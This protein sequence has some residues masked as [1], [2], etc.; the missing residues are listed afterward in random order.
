MQVAVGDHGITGVGADVP[1][2]HLEL[3]ERRCVPAQR[4]SAAP[5]LVGITTLPPAGGHAQNG[6]GLAGVN[7]RLAGPATGE[8]PQAVAG[9]RQVPY[10]F[11]AP[12][13]PD[14][15]GRLA[16]RVFNEHYAGLGHL[17]RSP[18]VRLIGRAIAGGRSPAHGELLSYLFFAPEFGQALLELGRDDARRWLEDD[19]D[20][21]PWQLGPTG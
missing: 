8:A 11:V 15:V 1:E 19:H 20:D 6:A 13:T 21:G 4:L 12:E 2:R 17:L 16:A 9:K 18:D 5:R 7:R 14:S 10:I 3:S